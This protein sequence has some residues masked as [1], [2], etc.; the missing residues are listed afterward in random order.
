MTHSI[1]LR[2]PAP[3]SDGTPSQGRRRARRG[4][5]LLE[6]IV[7]MTI[8]AISVTLFSRASMAV[9]R[10]NR[11]NDL[12]TK[13]DLAMQQ[14]LNFVNAL[15]F[16]S[17]NTTVIPA[18]KTFTTGDFRYTRRVSLAVT[19][20]SVAITVTIVPQTGTAADTLQKETVRFVRSIPVCG[21][22]LNTC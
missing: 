6:L 2:S 5:T 21:T 12:K 22:I 13:R 20:N 3:S 1:S 7:A 10:Y 9:N 8:L 4:V 16:A 14:Q 11:I 18:S 19:G 17:L 15:P